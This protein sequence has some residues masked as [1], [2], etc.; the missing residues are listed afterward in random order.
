MDDVAYLRRLGLDELAG[1]A[2][3]VPGLHALH[4]AHAERV[5]YECLEIWLGRPTGI[6]PAESTRRIL[7]G[8][9]G[10]CYHLNGAFSALLHTLGY[11]VT[12]HVGG[13]QGN[14]GQPAGAS[15]NHLVLTVTGLPSADAPGGAW[16]VDLGMGDG[17]HG[18]LP[19]VAGEH[20]QGPFVYRL[21]P[22][23]AEP[24]GWRFDHDPRGSFL[25]MD[26]RAEPTGMSAFAGQHEHLSTSP[27][28]GFVRIAT[29]AR[30]D[31]TG[32]DIV[33]NLVLTR[34]GDEP[35]R[36]ELTRRDDYFTA[37]AD[38]FGI[39][40]AEFTAAERD[41]LWT[42]LATAHEQWLAS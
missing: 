39:T 21:R 22:S 30:R 40:F 20:R 38:V 42:R 2:P 10:Y 35:S 1:Q 18:P 8:R 3:S 32:A 28:S 7:A 41:N 36:T 4:R 6:D 14:A 9:G 5:P 15:A 23:E 24:G 11:Q 25:G 17:L 37:L 19:L 26:F 34:V 33:R 31:A 29:A 16:L 27:E 13:V 12:R